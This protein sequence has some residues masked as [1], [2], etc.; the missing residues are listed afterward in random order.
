MKTINQ[1]LK[2]E[3]AGSVLLFLAAA[4]ALILANSPWYAWHASWSSS[5]LFWVNDGLMAIF[6]LLVG[7]ELKNH[8]LNDDQFNLAQIFLP[9]MAAVGGMLIPACIYAAITHADP[10]ALQG[11]ATP[12]ATDIAFALGALSLFGRRVPRSLKLFLL[13]LAI[14]DDIGAIL[15]IVLFYSHGLN[16][17]LMAE[18]LVLCG[19]L[20]SLQYFNIRSLFPYLAI[21]IVLW[22]RLLFSGIHPTISGVIL[23]LAIPGDGKTAS[24]AS[25]L[26]TCLNP[27]VSFLI[28]PIF[29]LTNMGL[30]LHDLDW[31]I[32]YDVVVLG[33][34]FGLFLGKQ[35]GVF[36]LTWCLV[37]CGAAKLPRQ[38][39]WGELYGVAL[40][41][42]IGF[43]MSLFLGT[44]S[45]Q[46][47]DS[48]AT[49]LAKVRFG[50]LLGSILSGLTGMIVLYNVFARHRSR[51]H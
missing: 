13:S 15:I 16:Y 1:F 47:L 51:D 19:V 44:L 46:H 31:H 35:L 36:G 40:L 18:A 24:P 39:G 37:T 3:A 30:P 32:F 43:T 45:F 7:L 14:F 25:R 27:W 10:I 50:V 20:F 28:M 9:A 5:L 26:E 38:V 2:W 23:A 11:W 34:I 49:Y 48:S 42:G 41:C 4:L 12:V 17:L 33:I 21:G 8:Y 29:A 6:F 22:Q